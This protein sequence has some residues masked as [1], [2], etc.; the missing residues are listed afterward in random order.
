MRILAC[1]VLLVIAAGW[2]VRAQQPTMQNDWDIRKTL[3]AIALHADRMAPFVDQI[4]PES[5][6]AAGAPAAYLAQARTCRSEVKAIAASAREISQTPE[7]LT[8]VLQLLF[9]IRTLES[10]LG[11]LG[12]GLRKYQNPPMADLLNGAVAEDAGNR[13]RL[14]QYALELAVAREQECHV[15]DE[16]AQRCRQSISRQPVRDSAS[17]PEKH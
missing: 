2:T 6:I 3:D 5:W 11:S 7:K 8:G 4:H 9:R 10:M 13:D 14:Q 12:E 16:E 15:A 1:S 17:Q